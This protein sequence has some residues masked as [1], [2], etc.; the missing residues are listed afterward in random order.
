MALLLPRHLDKI[1]TANAV[2]LLLLLA[3]G[4]RADVNIIDYKNLALGRPH[5][6]WDLPTGAKRYIQRASGYVATICGGVPTYENGEATGALPGK[7][8]R[9]AQAAPLA[10]AAE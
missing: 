6:T 3:P 5:L 10:R 1:D 7:L 4:Y 8:L 9:G 2:S